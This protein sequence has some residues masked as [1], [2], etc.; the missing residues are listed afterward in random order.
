MM[1]KQI[2]GGFFLSK[3][4][5]FSIVAT[6]MFA[7]IVAVV[8]VP[9][10]QA[11]GP[12]PD[13]DGYWAELQIEYMLSKDKVGGYPDGTFK[14]ANTITRAEFM[15]IVNNA[16]GFT[17]TE[18]KTFTDVSAADW[19]APEIAKA[20]AAGYITG[21][22]DGSMKPNANISRQEAALIITKAA[23]LDLN[24]I[25]LSKFKDAADIPNW[26]QAAVAACSK[27]GYINGYP[28]GTFQ[29]ANSITRAEAIVITLN[30]MP[31][32]TIYNTVGTFGPEKDSTTIS[33]DVIISVAGVKLRNTTIEGNLL[34]ARNVGEGEVGLTNV[35]VKGTTQINGGGAN[36]IDVGNSQLG[37]VMNYKPGVRIYCANKST[38]VSVILADGSEV[39]VEKGS[40]V[41]GVTVTTD[42]Q[43][44]LNG[45]FGNINCE[46]S[47]ANVTVTGSVGNITI[48]ND[49]AGSNINVNSGS[50]VSSITNNAA[51][52]TVKVESGGKVT[53]LTANAGINVTGS[54]TISNATINSDGVTIEQNPQKTTIADGIETKVGDKSYTGKGETIDTSDK[55]S[56]GGSSGSSGPSA[57]TVTAIK[58]DILGTNKNV[59]SNAVAFDLTGKDD[60]TAVSELTITTEPT[61]A[62]AGATISISQINARGNNFLSAPITSTIASNGK[63]TVTQLLGGIAKDG[64][65][66]IG[67][68]RTVLGT[69]N[70]VVTGTLSKSGYVFNSGAALTIT[71]TL[72]PATGAGT[73]VISNAYFTVEKTAVKTAKVTIKNS[74]VTVGQLKGSGIDF[75]TIVASF[76]GG[77]S[78]NGT[79]DL[80]ASILAKLNANVFD[81]LTLG[82]LIG[83]TVTFSDYTVIFN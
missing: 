3:R 46:G 35:I 62:I 82:Q 20:V 10:A 30:T 75:A 22:P 24:A 43:V 29:G 13:I 57:T 77:A 39:I 8:A 72:G 68:L 25:D 7:L 9:Q 60:L 28:D 31:E 6:L 83:K 63:V 65:V 27:A 14:P 36:S 18:S 73:G 71:I 33:G 48:E 79:D 51:N 2:E 23:K 66:S 11:A 52:A 53:T 41:Q 16:A 76:V 78:Y 21:Y 38:I 5:V 40:T 80:K 55:P 50:T 54:G 37:T 12:L 81:S 64:D 19:F 74:A 32:A 59:A 1:L 4:K 58:V 15:K 34:I 56:S 17:A 26:A 44:T 69:G 67:S 61:D 47:P 45:E 42:G 49:A 70:I